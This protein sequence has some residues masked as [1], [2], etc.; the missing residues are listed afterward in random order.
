M[1]YKDVILSTWLVFIFEITRNIAMDIIFE[2]KN[3]SSFSID[4]TFAY[5]I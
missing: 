2:V 4:I 1:I 5:N 3:I